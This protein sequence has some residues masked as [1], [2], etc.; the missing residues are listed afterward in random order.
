MAEFD[1]DTNEPQEMFKL[2]S[3]TFGDKLEV[4]PLN[5]NGLSDYV[6]HDYSGTRKQVERKTWTEILSDID[7]V[8]EQMQR[9]LTL[10]PNDEHIFLLEGM[11]IKDIIGTRVLKQTK[12]KSVFVK[13]Y[14]YKGR[15]LKAVYSWLY[16]IGKYVE[17]IPTATVLESATAL[18]ALYDA[19]QKENHLT[20][21]RHIKKMNFAPDPKI[22][23]YMNLLPKGI[24]EKTAKSLKRKFPTLKSMVFADIADFTACEGVGAVT[25][26]SIMMAL[27]TAK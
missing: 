1:A 18:V 12:T 21:H 19:D 27:G 7:A 5:A 20:L 13:G 26:R 9:H 15:R 11:A 22:L 3:Q 23:Q 2:L 16:Q 14:Q 17:I 6:W 25:A 24:G 8:E 4:G 10:H